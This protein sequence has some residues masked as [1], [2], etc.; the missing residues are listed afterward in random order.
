[1]HSERRHLAEPDTGVGEKQDDEPELAAG[2][3]ELVDFLM[4]QI[5]PFLRADA[6]ERNTGGRIPDEPIV[7]HGRGEDEREDT[8][9]TLRVVA[10]DRREATSEIQAWTALWLTSASFF[11]PHRGTMCARRMPA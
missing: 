2:V 5:H 8:V 10:A 6:G 11:V 7:F 9:R 4:A 1:V 3:G